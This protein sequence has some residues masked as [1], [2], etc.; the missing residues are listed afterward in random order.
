MPYLPEIDFRWNINN[1]CENLIRDGN[2]KTHT[3][4]LAHVKDEYDK[5]AIFEAGDFYGLDNDTLIWI[6]AQ[7]YP[8]TG[9]ADIDE[10][11][12]NRALFT[13]LDGCAPFTIEAGK[14]KL[15]KYGG[16]VRA[17]TKTGS[18]D[19]GIHVVPVVWDDCIKIDAR[20]C[21]DKDQHAI[22]KYYAD[23]HRK[24]D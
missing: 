18:A 5:F 13:V 24:K 17:K 14:K 1:Y 15:F 7:H 16:S 6:S 22:V 2:P 11:T 9:P 20:W 3:H 10:E 4:R 21:G 8:G 19:F 23:L 12:C